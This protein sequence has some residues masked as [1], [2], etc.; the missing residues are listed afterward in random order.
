MPKKCVNLVAG[1]TDSR[2]RLT[3]FVSFQPHIWRGTKPNATVQLYKVWSTSRFPNWLVTGGIVH[4]GQLN[5]VMW[6]Y[7][8]GTD[9]MLSDY[10]AQ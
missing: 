5:A 2:N 3:G 9:Y 8:V 1:K 10:R 7:W 4:P 6:E